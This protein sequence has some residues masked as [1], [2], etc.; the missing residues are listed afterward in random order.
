MSG[1]QISA[2]VQDT[3]RL[4]S[5]ITADIGAR[6]DRYDLI[7]SETSVSPRVN[8]A[9]RIGEGAVAHASYNHFFEPPPIE[10]VLS[11]SAGLTVHIAEIGRALPALK[12]A[13]GSQ[14][15]VGAT[16]RVGPVRVGLAGYAARRSTPFT[17]PCGPTR[18]ST[19]TPASPW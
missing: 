8:L 17:R 7:V 13:T 19:R 10:G 15:E 11:T 18:A 6:V 1:G 3:I 5:G 14:F 2:Y 9:F 12:P 16:G 4:A